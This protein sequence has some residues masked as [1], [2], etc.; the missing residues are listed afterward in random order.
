MYKD[1]QWNLR[2]RDTLGPA[3]L[4]SV[5]RL[6][7]SRRVKMIYCYGK[8]VQNDVLCW[9]AV[10]FLEGPLSE[11]PLSEVPLYCSGGL[12]CCDD[13]LTLIR[14]LQCHVF[15]QEDG[16]RSIVM[17]PA[18]TSLINAQAV[19]EHFGTTSIRN[20][21]IHGHRKGQVSRVS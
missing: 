17:A 6:S 4:S 7:S 2:I 5:E 8:G 19:Q 3:I 1:I 12:L 9:E 15:I 10:P 11:V 16:E 14:T 21:P 13:D 20:I 18:S